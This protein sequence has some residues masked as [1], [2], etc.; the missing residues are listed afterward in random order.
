MPS[1]KTTLTSQRNFRSRIDERKRSQQVHRAVTQ[2]C[3]VP[4]AAT[5]LALLLR[6]AAFGHEDYR[7]DSS[8]HIHHMAK[9]C[10]RFAKE[11]CLSKYS[12]SCLFPLSTNS[13]LNTLSRA[14]PVEMRKW[15]DQCF[16]VEKYVEASGAQKAPRPE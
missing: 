7:R 16:C 10:R 5:R 3:L 15:N 6:D 13:R 14:S 9:A 2:D 11:L 1:K 12:P 4:V 8:V